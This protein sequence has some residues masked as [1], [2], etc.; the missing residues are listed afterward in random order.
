MEEVVV[1]FPGFTSQNAAY[2]N[3]RRITIESTT[4]RSVVVPFLVVF[5]TPS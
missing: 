1:F 4:G 3:V 5:V 2:A